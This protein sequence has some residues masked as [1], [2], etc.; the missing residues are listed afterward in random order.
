MMH[1]IAHCNNS[2]CPSASRCYRY[3]AHLEAK[4]KGFE[5]VTYFLF[6][7]EDIEKIKIEKRCSS[8]W[9]TTYMENDE[10]DYGHNVKNYEQA[11]F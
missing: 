11:D 3:Q 8:F 10:Y 2:T 7:E 5:Y 6:T 1:D 9:A 4:V